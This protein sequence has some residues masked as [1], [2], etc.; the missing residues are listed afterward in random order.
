MSTTQIIQTVIEVLL[1]VAVVVAMLYEPAIADW[2]KKQ[3]EKMLKAFKK[4]KEFRK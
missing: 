2:E 4:R 3:G 1:I